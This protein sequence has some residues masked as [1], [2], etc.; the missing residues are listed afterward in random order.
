MMFKGQIA[1]GLTLEALDSLFATLSLA[2]ANS[3]ES[4]HTTSVHIVP[5]LIQPGIF[6]RIVICMTQRPSGSMQ[7]KQSAN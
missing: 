1:N 5:A 2:A 6:L 7:S 3:L 4:K